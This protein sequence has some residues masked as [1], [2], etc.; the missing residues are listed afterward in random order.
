MSRLRAITN[1]TLNSL[2]PATLHRLGSFFSSK[3]AS[4]SLAPEPLLETCEVNERKMPRRQ[5][6]REL[7]QQ[8]KHRF[9]CELD[10][11]NA[12]ESA[13][14]DVLLLAHYLHLGCNNSEFVDRVEAL[15]PELPRQGCSDV[16]YL[17]Q[18]MLH[19]R[20]EKVLGKASLMLASSRLYGYEYFVMDGQALPFLG[21]P[22]YEA[23]AEFDRAFGEHIGEELR[24][25][26]GTGICRVCSQKKKGLWVVEITHGGAKRKEANENNSQAIDILRQPIEVDCLIYDT[27]YND[28]RIHMENKSAVVLRIYCQSFGDCLYGNHLCWRPNFKY[29]LDHFNLRREELQQLLARGAERLSNPTAGKLTIAVASVSYNISH[30]SYGGA[31]TTD[32]YKKSNAQGLNNSMAEGE[33]LVPIEA[34]ITSIVL[35]FTHGSSKIKNI[36]VRLTDRHRTLESEAIPGIEDWLYEEGFSRRVRPHEA[37]ACGQEEGKGL[38]A[39]ERSAGTD[40]NAM[41]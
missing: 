22:R 15:L 37:G 11:L 13:D 35:K 19:A 5:E 20:G 16:E 4:F 23:G 28:I 7:Y 9:L 12:A 17:V 33:Y 1:N 39:A 34:A 36:R 6:V 31:T 25:R 21:N 29:Y 40:T 14:A 24:K 2:P 30:S 3:G 27:R 18:A 26:Y 8:Y 32:K 38:H 41:Q 10:K